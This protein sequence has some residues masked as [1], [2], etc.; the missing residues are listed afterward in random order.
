MA[1][2]TRHPGTVRGDAQAF[3]Q[4]VSRFQDEVG[5]VLDR[6]DF[7]HGPVPF[8]A[9]MRMMFPVAESLGDLIYRKDDATAQNLR[10]VLEHEFEEVRGG[11]RGKAA[12]LTLLYRHSLTHQD[13]LRRITSTGKEIGWKVTAGDDGGHL[14]VVRAMSGVFLIEFQPRSFFRDIVGVCERAQ[15]KRWRGEVKKRYNNWMSLDLDSARSNSTITAAK[16]ELAAI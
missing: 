13:E 5:R 6:I 14:Q 4:I 12:L 9:L 2:R 3:R 15:R 10:S 7:V 16:A 8:W 1:R 11:Y